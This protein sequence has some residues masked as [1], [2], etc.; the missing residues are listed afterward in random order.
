VEILRKEVSSLSTKRTH[1]STTTPLEVGGVQYVLEA[2]QYAQE[3]ILLTSR[4]I[5][6]ESM[7]KS[8]ENLRGN[9]EREWYR[10]VSAILRLTSDSFSKGTTGLP[11]NTRANTRTGVRKKASSIT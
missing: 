4:L 9:Y 3:P 2:L 6:P 1:S 10:F 8:R 5:L 7:W 11:K